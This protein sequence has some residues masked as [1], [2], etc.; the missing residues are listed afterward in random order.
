MIRAPLQ[1]LT[2]WVEHPR[3]NGCPEMTWARKLKK[4]MKFKGLLVN[5]KEWRVI[6]SNRSEWRSRA[7][8]KPMLHH[9][10]K[11]ER[12]ITQKDT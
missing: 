11:D 12:C 7:Y 5:F 9:E 2:G 6:A 4:A 10:S 3:P 8:S 1:L